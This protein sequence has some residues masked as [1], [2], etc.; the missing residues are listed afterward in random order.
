MRSACHRLLL[1]ML[2]WGTNGV[3]TAFKSLKWPVAR[4]I[5]SMTKAE[6]FLSWWIHNN[7]VDVPADLDETRA[8]AHRL[9]EM[10]S[11]AATQL[12]IDLEDAALDRQRLFDRMIDAI[13]SRRMT[14]SKS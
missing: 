11:S 2:R 10:F 13:T 6:A 4:W 14:Q 9:V 8:W 5:V 7:V 12:G 1:M 3:P